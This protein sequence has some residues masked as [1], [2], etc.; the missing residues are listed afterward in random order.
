MSVLVAVF[1]A[2]GLFFFTAGT[3]GLLRLPDVYTRTHG[4]TKC[5]TL[6]ALLCIIALMIY[7]GLSLGIVKLLLLMVFLW[8]ANPTAAH[9]ITKAAM[10]SGVRV[11]GSGTGDEEEQNERIV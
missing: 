6:G 4:A 8:I 9:L 2:A 3:I 7:N 5:D 10:A 11:C 1:M